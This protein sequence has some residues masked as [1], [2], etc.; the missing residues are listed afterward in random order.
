[1]F[2]IIDW[3]IATSVIFVAFCEI[4]ALVWIYGKLAIYYN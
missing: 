1:M 3:F 2:Q 4:V